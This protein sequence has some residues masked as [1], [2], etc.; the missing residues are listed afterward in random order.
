MKKL[1]ILLTI[2]FLFAACAPQTELG[3]KDT[4]TL[5]PAME[6]TEE[7]TEES[8]IPEETEA[9]ADKAEVDETEATEEQNTPEETPDTEETVEETTTAFKPFS[10]KDLIFYTMDK[11]PYASLQKNTQIIILTEESSYLKYP[12][13]EVI[14]TSTDALLTAR[15]IGLVTSCKDFLKAY[16]GENAAV[17]ETYDKEG[18]QTLLPYDGT[19][20]SSSDAVDSRYLY[21]GFQKSGSDWTPIDTAELTHILSGK[22]TLADTTEIVT[23]CVTLDEVGMINLFYALY[24]TIG[25]LTY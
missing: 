6:S 16:G 2:V 5:P 4:E 3:T 13:H 22:A 14:T 15:D 1:S 17:W 21:I 19:L 18:K 11:K 25:D 8:T 10:S 23:F 7:V 24:T 20:P 12:S 9:E